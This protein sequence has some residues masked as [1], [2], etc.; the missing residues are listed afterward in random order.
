[1]AAK[2]FRAMRRTYDADQCRDR[3]GDCLGLSRRLLEEKDE[4]RFVDIFFLNVL[5]NSMFEIENSPK[6]NE[7]KRRNA[8]TEL[9]KKKIMPQ[10]SRAAPNR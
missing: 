4:N 2:R 7:Q 3:R 6:P 10:E 1:M 8:S 5:E 9:M